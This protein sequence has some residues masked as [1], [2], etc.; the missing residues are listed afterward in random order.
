MTTALPPAVSVVIATYNRSQ[1]LRYAIESVR[2]STFTDWEL[3]VVGDACTDDTA[4]CVAAFAD[5]RI[6][7]IN[8]AKR[9]ADQSGPNNHGIAL[10][11]GRYI[12]LLNHDDM[13][14][15]QHLSACVAELESTA[16]DLVWTPCALAVPA[17]PPAAEDLPCRFIM[18]GVSPHRDYTPDS[19]YWASSWVFRRPLAGQVGPWLTA[20]KTYLTPSQAWLFKAW[21]KGAVLRFLPTVSVIV[22]PA[23]YWPVSYRRRESPEHEWLSRWITGDPKHRERLLED[24]ALSEGMQRMADLSPPFWKGVKRLCKRPLFALLLAMG[25][26]PA[27]FILA[28]FYGQRRG[29][30]I[31]ARRK[32]TG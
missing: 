9:C 24:L 5:P 3:I 14:L 10:S 2:N 32:Q 1:V 6:R 12:A 26:H 21:R 27:T 17:Y 13:H 25:I 7:F 19:F 28:T 30:Q 31:R 20:D 18:A 11:R 8:L 22:V 23:G 29:S 4:E 15:P 16:A